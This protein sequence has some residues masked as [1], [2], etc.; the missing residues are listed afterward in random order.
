MTAPVFI[1]LAIRSSYSLL[2]SMISPSD[3]AKWCKA[4]GV[5][6][7]AISDRN[8]LFGALEFS[9]KL[10]ESGLQ[11]IM[12][13]CFEF[14]DGV[15]RSEPSRVSLYAQNEVG[16]RRLMFLS[17]RAFL[18]AP[19]GVPKL[20]RRYLLEETEGLI[21]L[22]GGAEGEVARHI[23]KSR[24]TDARTELSTLAAAYP[25]RC[26]VEI[27]RHG[28][29]A[30]L[31]T[32]AG[33]TE[34]A[35]ELG[36]PLVATHDARFMKPADRNAHDAL[37]CI[38]NGEYLGQDD[39]K[40]VEAS[41]YLQSPE[42]MA[43]L[44]ADLPE[45]LQSS[46]EIAQRCVVRAQMRNPI[47]PAFSKGGR[48][49]GDELRLQAREGLEGRLRQAD[50]LYADKIQYEE[51]L[52]YELGI[53]ERM[54]FPGY[55]LI[56]SDFIKWAKAN[57]IPVGPGRG[58]GAG[59]LVAWALLITDLDPI[60]FD[61]LFERFLNPERVSMPD[62]DVD[63]CQERRGEVIRYVRDKYGADSVAMIITFGT[64]QAKAVVR[65]VGRVMQMPYGQVD[66]LAKLIPFNPAKPPT[67][68]EAIAAEPKFDEEISAD[69]RVGELIETARSLEG[70][71]RNA[72]THAAGVVIA[73]RPLVEL[74]PLYNDPRAELPATQ[75]NMKYAEMAG[76]V[77]FD[78]LGLKTLTVIDRA[79]KFIEAGQK[80]I[81]PAWTS[82]DDAASYD[83]MASGET[84]G[85][86]QLE[87]AG[88]RDTLR[89]VR[90]NNIEDL[91]AII[92]LY[93]PGPMENI[94]V[95]VQGK[96]DPSS[97]TYQHPDLR[98]VLEATYGVPVYQ[99]QVM[100]MAQEIAGYSLGE[101]DLLRRAMGK[102][103]L[104]EMI[105]QRKRF[106]DGAASNKGMKENL[107]NEI[108]DTMEKFA[109][110]GFNKSHAAAYALIGYQTAYLKCHFPVE[111]L[112]ASMSLD[113][114]NT[115][116]LAAFFQE[117]KR[118][119]IPVLAPDIN[120]STA[121]FDVRNGAIVYALGA[122]KGV[123]LE[124]MKHVCNVRSE[125]GPFADLFEFAERVD[126]RHVNK[127]AFES[128]ARAGA[129]DGL[130][131]NRARVLDA[132]GTLAQHAASAAGDRQGGQAGLFAD[133]EPALRPPLP[134][135][136]NWTSQQ[137]L[138]E[139]FK[140][141]GFYFSGHPLDDVLTSLDRDR[142]TLIME[143]EERAGE[144][145]PLE[146][147]GIVRARTDKPGRNGGKYAFLTVSDPTGEREMAVYSDALYQYSDLLRP[148]KAI[149]L[150]VSVRQN[151]EET[152]LIVERA[153][154]L[155]SARISKPSGL[156][157]VRL[158]PGANPAELAQ[159]VQLLEGLSDPDRGG[160]HLEMP[161][162]DGRTVTVKLPQTYTISLKAQRA[163]KDIPGVEKVTPRL[164]A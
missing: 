19:D 112:A 21:L 93:R 37:M 66:R 41:Q 7:A 141:I 81:G 109:G 25:G 42:E 40:R 153:V 88:M 155:E 107:A 98:P 3:V 151:G 83:L 136:R 43:D 120:T 68:D 134:N 162:E 52:E 54:G 26:Y 11:P 77:K 148:G 6:A 74:V 146:M 131:Q 119:R 90:P 35:Y 140:A 62:F 126:P 91:I 84:L 20:H 113:I 161:L 67:L 48:S 70:L 75:F 149:A 44:F 97:V 30:E 32:E 76:L 139:E 150:T 13:C 79:L 87:G 104:E 59:S 108:F 143:I 159:V 50:R 2:E 129:F 92:S 80:T 142:M 16:Y 29:Q 86:F 85:V 53:I 160:I 45:A 121:D 36:L 65:D 58:S 5:P 115:D 31:K 82:L 154:E 23:L 111:F 124:A 147:I 4:Y 64:L 73:D 158:A 133:A 118:L 123:G 144:G 17:S 78:F 72:G 96:E 69:A 156:L 164:A 102:K 157:V 14:T 137:K 33:L 15:P 125:G 18:D 38:A 128:L 61:L 130:E 57:G 103:K 12:A 22:T 100:R 47:L 163:L 39:R 27:T 110:Y 9:L 95:Y 145:R 116:K 63:F 1:P 55:F 138:D 132:A 8:N 106:V 49:E 122:L 89:R 105:A 34:L 71:Y 94:P 60:R 127:K 114:G 152:R 101:A 99:E 117:A 135:P 46:V 51:R 10:A 28:T 24:M 56:V